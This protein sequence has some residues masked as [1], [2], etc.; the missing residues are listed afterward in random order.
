LGAENH[1]SSCIE[2]PVKDDEME[3]QGV[4]AGVQQV[5]TLI[6]PPYLKLVLVDRSV[7]PDP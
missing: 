4:V 2:P 1:I 6:L 7:A 5:Q 3:W